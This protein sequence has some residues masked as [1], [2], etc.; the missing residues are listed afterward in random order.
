MR[1]KRTNPAV[2]ASE[3]LAQVAEDMAGLAAKDK[4]SSNLMQ[5]IAAR[6]RKTADMIRTKRPYLIEDE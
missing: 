1:T 6:R 5:R 4:P 2:A 3:K